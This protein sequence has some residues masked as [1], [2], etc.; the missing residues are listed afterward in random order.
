MDSRIKGDMDGIDT[1]RSLRERFKV[2]VIYLTAH[3]DRDTLDRARFAEPLGYIVKPFQESELRASIEMA[4]HKRAVDLEAA[5][6][7]D[8]LSAAL[9]LAGEG[10]ITVDAFG[11]V[12][13]LNAAAETWTGWSRKDAA[14]RNVGQVF[15]LT[16]GSPVGTLVTR[17]IRT[18][19]I[20][21]LEVDATLMD[22]DGKEQAVAGTIAP[23]KDHMGAAAGAV[24]LFGAAKEA[25]D[26]EP[27]A[28]TAETPGF[29]MVAE[30]PAFKRAAQFAKRVA[31]SE[32]TAIFIE[33]ES[34]SG[35]DVLARYIHHHSRRQAAPFLAIN[36]AAI[37]E[38][39]L[40]SELF[41]FEKGAFTDAKALKRGILEMA[42]GGTV[43]LDEIGEMP[44]GLQAKLLR[45]L[46]EHCFRRLGGTSDIHVDLRIITATNR[47]LRRAIQ[48]GRFRLDLYY[49][50]NVFQISV[51]PLRERS[52]DLLPLA[53]YFLRFCNQRYKRN[54]LGLT[55]EAVALLN[56]HS[57][58]GN[59]RELRN[60]IERAMVLEESAWV[61]PGS[62][63]DLHTEFSTAA[64]V[65]EA[66]RVPAPATG[67]SLEQVERNMLVGALEKTGWNQ[68][69]AAR[70]LSITRDTL[71]YKM[72]K[73]NLR[74]AGDACDST[75]D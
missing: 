66:P 29:E 50:L 67:L 31:V 22:R 8:V 46:E 15:Q 45:V 58:P 54:L 6:E 75:G 44:P 28:A 2:P 10:V 57:W 72:K 73:F 20:A 17:V 56:S 26:P 74:R 52:E 59:V 60:T 16:G 65:A 37:P 38:T 12:T 1:A 9:N 30:S 36:C 64:P 19:E 39:L 14:G 48:Q 68:T 51:P 27:S 70:L 62:L 25:A 53:N 4:L 18:A 69:R 23:V 11:A 24:I 33:G 41:G 34:G 21:E 5:R 55:S 13:M 71:R 63:G 42:N 7:R 49:R 32:A 47:D 3:A 61:Q 43:F 35:K 40:E